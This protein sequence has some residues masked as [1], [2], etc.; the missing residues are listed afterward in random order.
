MNKEVEILKSLFLHSSENVFILNYEF[1]ILW[2][3]KADADVFF[4]GI[5]VAEL[6]SKEVKPLKSGEYFIEF[7]GLEFM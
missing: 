7:D 4:S 3:N 1:Q 5:S 6:F 2:S